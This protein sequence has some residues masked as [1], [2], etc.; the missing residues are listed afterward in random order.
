LSQIDFASID[1]SQLGLVFLHLALDG[2]TPEIRQATQ[3]AVA[4][5]TARLPQLTNC[6]IRDSVNTFISRGPPASK[7][8]SSAED[9]AKPWNDHARLSALLLSSVSFDVDLDLTIREDLI[10]ELIVI[11][12]HDLVCMF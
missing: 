5:S 11:G 2:S 7:A 1:R 6:V 10:V 8:A 4:E 9:L 12:H 3:T